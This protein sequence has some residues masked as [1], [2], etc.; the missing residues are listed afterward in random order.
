MGHRIADTRSGLCCALKVVKDN[1]RAFSFWR[2]F[3]SRSLE[4]LWTAA[5]PVE[6]RTTD[7]SPSAPTFRA[8]AS[9]P[10]AH[11][12][13][14]AH[15]DD[16]FFLFS[17]VGLAPLEGRSRSRWAGSLCPSVECGSEVRRPCI[18]SLGPCAASRRQVASPHLAS[19][20]PRR[21]EVA[22]QAP[23]CHGAE[24]A[25]P[26]RQRRDAAAASGR[27][28][29]CLGRL[30]WRHGDHRFS[31]PTCRS[32]DDATRRR[33]RRIP[34]STTITSSSRTSLGGPG[35]RPPHRARTGSTP[36]PV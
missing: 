12:T 26:V 5:Q 16:E 36:R 23:R 20:Q 3:V 14:A 10:V 34:T 15:D 9:P 30:R 19:A 11:L 2:L 33:S 22:C 4:G 17:C 29:S 25:K 31:S 32:V 21:R 18:V 1:Q 6:K 27:C 8:C 28:G 35:A 7:A 13:T 24:L